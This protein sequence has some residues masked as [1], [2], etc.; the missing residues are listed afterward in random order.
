MS[1]SQAREAA[2]Y[3]EDAGGDTAGEEGS[4]TGMSE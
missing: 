4:G 1:L 2:F 3:E